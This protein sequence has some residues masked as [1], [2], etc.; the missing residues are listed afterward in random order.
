MKLLV[1]SLFIFWISQPAN[2]QEIL[3]IPKHPDNEMFFLTQENSLVAVDLLPDPKYFG[4][5]NKP[6]EDTER[7]VKVPTSFLSVFGLYPGM[8]I[9]NINVAQ[10]GKKTTYTLGKDFYALLKLK[11]DTYSDEASKEVPTWNKFNVLLTDNPS[12]HKQ[13]LNKI[14]DKEHNKKYWISGFAYAGKEINLK[15]SAQERITLHKVD[16]SDPFF[17]L[18]PDFPKTRI[19]SNHAINGHNILIMINRSSISPA[20]GFTKIKDK[21]YFLF[22]STYDPNIK[23]VSDDSNSALVGNWI[24]GAKTFFYDY[25]T[26]P[27][28]DCFNLMI[29]EKEKISRVEFECK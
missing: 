13:I 16:Q 1:I 22:R 3:T 26:P 19:Y 5:L 21:Y 15:E 10:G 27:E 6:R 8:T 28:R 7:I 29:L 2:G 20:M 14:K 18:N 24:N 11:N 23:V 17:K 4:D 25:T 12:D 9:Q